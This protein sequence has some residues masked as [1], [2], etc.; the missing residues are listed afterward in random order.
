MNFNELPVDA[1]FRFIRHGTLLTKTTEGGYATP[2]AAGQKAAPDVEVIPE[3]HLPAPVTRTALKPDD[4]ALL[5]KALD[6]LEAKA[7]KTH[8]LAAARQAL[9]RLEA[10][11][12]LKTGSQS[13]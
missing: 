12:K 10:L 4:V 2:G 3:A 11:S 5:S 7:G 13:G 8:E 6:D 1:K 9:R